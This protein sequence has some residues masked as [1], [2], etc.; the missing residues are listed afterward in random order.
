MKNSNNP[1]F[2]EKIDVVL[3]DYVGMQRNEVEA[4]P[5][6][7]DVKIEWIEE[8][9]NK[10]AAGYV[11]KQSPAGGR[12]VKQGQTI[13]LTVS[14][15]T[16]YITLDDYAHMAQDTAAQELKDLGLNVLVVQ[17]VDSSVAVGTVIRTEPAA[18]EQVESGSTVYLYVSRQQVATTTKAPGIVGLT[19]ADAQKL[20]A[21]YKLILGAATDSYS[22]SVPVGVI[23][24]QSVEEGEE[25]NING[26]IAVVVSIGPE[27]P[28]TTWVDSVVGLPEDEA[29]TALNVAGLRAVVSY[30]YSD[31]VEKGVVIS[32]NVNGIEVLLDS[33][34]HLVVSAGAD[35]TKPVAT[36]TPEGSGQGG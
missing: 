11:Y 28:K 14:L 22:D 12:T 4:D 35:P 19:V 20:L 26:R 17:N 1:L 8:Y 29:K 3:N 25:I 30:E 36:P 15:G 23:M 31:T 34:V 18:H 10:H 27:P 13:T 21:T 7:S 2:S 5:G 6:A 16:K 24:F 32:Q 9:S 33:E